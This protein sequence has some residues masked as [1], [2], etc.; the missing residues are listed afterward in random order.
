MHEIGHNPK[1]ETDFHRLAIS[2]GNTAHRDCGF[3]G[4]WS[5]IRLCLLFNHRP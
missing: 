2:F 4:L 5:K 1:V 3:A